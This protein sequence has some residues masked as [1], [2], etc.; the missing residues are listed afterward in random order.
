MRSRM[1][2]AWWG[3]PVPVATSV[4]HNAEQSRYELL[5]DGRLAGI[6]DYRAGDGDVVVFPHTE[7]VP[8]LRGA[9]LGAV[10]VRAALDHVRDTGRRVIPTCWYVAE[11]IDANPEYRDLLTA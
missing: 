4:Q 8:E 10:L 2:C 3:R 5:L 6:A 7:I 9:G 1:H 11:F